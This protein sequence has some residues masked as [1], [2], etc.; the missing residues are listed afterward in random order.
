MGVPKF[1]RF[2]SER[3]PLVLRDVVTTDAGL[4]DNL[5]IDC[6]AIIHESASRENKCKMCLSEKDIVERVLAYITHLFDVVRPKKLLFIAVDGV[7]PRTK[8]NQQRERRV[9]G[10]IASRMPE[11][12]PVEICGESHLA[13]WK[14][15]LET[16]YRGDIPHFER[17]SISPGT[18]FMIR[19]TR[20]LTMFLA[21]RKTFCPAWRDITLILS[22]VDVPGEGEHKFLDYIRE[23]QRKDPSYLGSESH[24][25]HG[26]DADLI[27]LALS[28]HEPRIGIF[29]REVDFKPPFERNGL[30]V[31]LQP[32]DI[33]M[34]V[35]DIG[36]LRQYMHEEFLFAFQH[37]K[38]AIKTYKGTRMWNNAYNTAI[39]DALKKK[40]EKEHEDSSKDVSSLS[41][42][43]ISLPSEFGEK[44]EEGEEEPEE[45]MDPIDVVEFKN[46]FEKDW[47][48]HKASVLASIPEF[49]F[50][51]VIDDFVVICLFIGN[52][53]LPHLAGVSV[54]TAETILD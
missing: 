49:D 40:E 30:D 15:E 51:R 1:A 52:D 43:I 36:V 35:L 7:A 25:F 20:I 13:D 27:F 41:S 9:A 39:K 2:V 14:A 6:N 8:M 17:T 33:N 19:F 46:R 31:H 16:L 53:F 11:L 45:F 10:A 34:Q 3:Y 42:D 32:W 54:T 47:E 26:L 24:A 38:R 44:E 23:R 50:E 29:R 5:Y 12:N 48:D 22:G 21:N 18:P 37:G 28:T 4:Y